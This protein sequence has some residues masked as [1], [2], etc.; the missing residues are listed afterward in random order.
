[1]GTVLYS[2]GIFINR[3]FDE[4]NLSAP[5]MV[6][7]IHQEYAKA[8]AEILETNTFGATRHRLAAFGF[9]DKLKAINQAG[10]RLAREAAKD[11]AV[12]APAN[13]PVKGRHLPPR[14]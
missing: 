3:C 14:P 12:V 9:A 1:M 5:D 10:V 7:Q 13:G 6:R 4:L 8:G 2:R 11:T